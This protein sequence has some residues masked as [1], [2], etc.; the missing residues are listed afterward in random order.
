MTDD[1]L[2]DAPPKKR[3][4]AAEPAPQDPEK[5]INRPVE[6]LRVEVRRGRRL[7]QVQRDRNE[8]SR[9]TALVQVILLVVVT[10]VLVAVAMNWDSIAPAPADTKNCYGTV[11]AKAVHYNA[12]NSTRYALGIS[13][14][15]VTQDF[16]V[17]KDMYDRARPAHTTAKVRDGKVVELEQRETTKCAS[18]IVIGAL[19]VAVVGCVGYRRQRRCRS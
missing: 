1:E 11:T 2:I 12:D 13:C 19:T 8:R 6:D 14:N 10:S 7:E 5:R 17:T 15:G 4:E 3:V 9:R 16:T 18:V